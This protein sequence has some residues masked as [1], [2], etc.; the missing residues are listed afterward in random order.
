MNSDGVRI[1]NSKKRSLWPLWLG[2]LNLT[3][4]LRC[5]FA[6]INLAKLWLGRGKPD[7]N[8]FFSQI[9]ESLQS[10]SSIEWKG[11]FWEVNFVTKLLV[12]DLPA[13]A[14]ILNMQ[15][16]NTYFGCTL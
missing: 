12:A 9:K 14:S 7:W 1:I 2:I 15:Q 5:M 4:V 10:E 8:V 11:T 6:N 3:P 13:K 16:F